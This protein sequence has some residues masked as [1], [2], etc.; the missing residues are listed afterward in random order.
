M[1]HGKFRY[2]RSYCITTPFFEDTTNYFE[3]VYNGDIEWGDYDNDNYLDV[4]ITGNSSTI[5][6][7]NNGDNKFCFTRFIFFHTSR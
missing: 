2:H 7:R 3:G 1:W 5:L 4:I 6:Y